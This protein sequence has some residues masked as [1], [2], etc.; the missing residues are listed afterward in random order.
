VGENQ[1]EKPSTLGA[2]PSN[3]FPELGSK[4]IRVSGN[5]LGKFVEPHQALPHSRGA[6]GTR[7]H[8][9]LVGRQG[10]DVPAARRPPDRR[11]KRR[12]NGEAKMSPP[13]L[14]L[15]EPAV[16]R[17]QEFAPEIEL[18]TLPRGSH[19]QGSAVSSRME[20]T[21]DP[22]QIGPGHQEIDQ[23]ELSNGAIERRLADHGGNAMGGEVI[24]EDGQLGDQSRVFGPRL[25]DLH[26]EVLDNGSGNA[27]PASGAQACPE[28]RQETVPDGQPQEIRPV[29]RCAQQSRHIWL[30]L[31]WPP[32]PGTRQD[33]RM[34]R[35]LMHR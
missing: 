5:H 26:G 2:V 7:H 27:F 22:H 15:L 25:L 24:E 14:D 3:A 6:R 13:D 16:A 18:G 17:Q 11:A 12:R 9:R 33:E 10:Q 31:A 34:F 35:A 19:P 32:G 1:A 8:E 4:D 30:I 29:E 20:E 23:G 21:A 28:G